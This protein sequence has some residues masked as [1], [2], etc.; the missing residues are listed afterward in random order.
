M[1]DDFTSK[2]VFSHD[3][4][5]PY[6]LQA[7]GQVEAINNILKH[8]FQCMI[9][10][11][12]RNWHLILYSD[13]WAYCTSVRNGTRFTLFQLVY[14]LEAILPIQCEIPSLKLAIEFI[15]ETS[16]EEAHILNFIH[17]GEMGPESTMANEAHKR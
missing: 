17:L 6:Y 2:L 16:V 13:L 15:P 12:K 7:N 10:V 9:G 5:T 4:S 1:M 14:G 11:H 8:T 3:N